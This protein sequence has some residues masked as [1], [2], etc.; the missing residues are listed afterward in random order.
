LKAITWSTHSFSA[1]IVE[2]LRYQRGLL[3]SRKLCLLPHYSDTIGIGNIVNNWRILGRYIGMREKKHQVGIFVDPACN[4]RCEPS[5]SVRGL[6]SWINVVAPV[7][8]R[9]SL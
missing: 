6:T 1:V 7:A 4:S 2:V 8:T 3:V 9:K 5:V